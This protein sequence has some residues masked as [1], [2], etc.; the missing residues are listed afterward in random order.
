MNA[1]AARLLRALAAL[2]LA[3]CADEPF[4]PERPAVCAESP[5]PAGQPSATPLLALVP[6]PALTAAQQE[7]LG[8]IRAR[9][10][11]AEVHVGRLADDF[12][13]LLRGRQPIEIAVSPTRGFV[14]VP[15]EVVPRPDGVSWSAGLAAEQG[16]A[17]LVLNATGISGYVASALN[18]SYTLES[19]GDGLVAVVCVDRSKHLPD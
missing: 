16:N 8:Y 17:F 12:A 7:L 14:A 1:T 3:G 6:A 15:T 19:V 5:R 11:S 2:A 10:S 4:V 18:Q 9:P 13:A